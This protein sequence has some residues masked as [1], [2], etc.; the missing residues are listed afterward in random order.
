M[1]GAGGQQGEAT[2]GHQGAQVGAASFAPPVFLSPQG[3]VQR[4]PKARSQ[5][6]VQQEQ[7]TPGKEP[8]GNVPGAPGEAGPAGTAEVLEVDVPMEQPQG[9]RP[10]ADSD[11]EVAK[12]KG[13]RHGEGSKRGELRPPATCAG[14]RDR[15]RSPEDRA[16]RREEAQ[17]EK[18][19]AAPQ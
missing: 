2:E 11:G 12:G 8:Q 5:E 17:R 6:R 14:R 4:R 16:G 1:S 19:Q 13:G 18:P 15:L 3:P 10:T 9:Q 7:V